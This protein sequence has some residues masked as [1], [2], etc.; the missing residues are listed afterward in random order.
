MSIKP[1]HWIRRMAL[2][3]NMI[4]P[5]VENQVREG[6]VSYGLSSYGYDIRVADEFRIFTPATGQLTVVDPKQ[7]DSRAMAP[8]QGD[9]CIIPPNSFALARTVEYFRI[10][11]NV[12]TICLGKS[13]YARCFSGDTRV[14]LVDGT[15]PTLDEMCK[16]SGQGESFWGY[17]LG[18]F[19]QVMV[20][21]LDT[22]RWIGRD[23]LVEI[24]LDNGEIISCTPDH[25][26]I[27]RDGR[28][29][30]ADEL[31][32]N[33]S[34]MPLYRQVA[35]GYEMV[36]QPSNSHMLPTHRL[37]DEWNLRQGLYEDSPGTH[38]HHIDFDRRNN[39]PW[40]ITRMAAKEH[41][42]MHNR[43]SFGD[44]F[45]PNEHSAAIR[46]AF[47]RLRQ[48]PD[49]QAAFNERQ[50]QRALDFWRDG[51]YSEAR[52]QLQQRHLDNWT[53][54]RR[55]AQGAAMRSYYADPERRQEQSERST[56]MWQRAS[57]ERRRAQADFARQLKL[58]DEITAEVVRAALDETGSIRGAA[59]LLDCDRSVFRRFPDVITSFQGRSKRR[60]H[61]IAAIRSL[62][63]IHDVYCLTV[64][65]AGNFALAAGVF[66]SNCGII[67]NVT[68]FEP[69]WEGHVTIEISNT[70][71]LPAKIYANEGIAQVLF[72]EGDPP[73]VSYADRKGKYQAQRGITLPKL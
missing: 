23:V 14:A 17:S 5:F 32:P 49:W 36:Y 25:K 31:R 45:D 7:I 33:D 39:A 62:P 4:E 55:R 10:P 53:E 16:R 65:E 15:S 43:I 52:L 61:R 29:R 38:R 40:N 21:L 12:L 9:V 50:R 11:R 1:D 27:L 60:N 73:E 69:E 2:E 19:G 47:E 58:R 64:P 44:D 68:P 34:L 59:R 18:Q 8:Y 48:D 56:I 3:H 20:T 67:V 28:M 26:F 63:G 22:P 24:E 46:E 70:T 41:I 6:V 37:A 54:E 71:P 13:T 57:D 35:R 72:F 30:Q 66:T 51:H 42:Q